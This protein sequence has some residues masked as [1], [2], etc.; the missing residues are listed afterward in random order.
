MPP[1]ERALRLLPPEMSESRAEVEFLLARALV[2]GKLDVARGQ[3]VARA[4]LA[5]FVKAGFTDQP[6]V[7][8]LRAWMSRH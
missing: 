4:A 7:T 6:T 2:E 8:A 1:L 5:D 3:A